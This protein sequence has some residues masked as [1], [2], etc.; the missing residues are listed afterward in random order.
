MDN[1]SLIYRKGK[2]FYCE[3]DHVK[4]TIHAH[5]YPLSTAHLLN[6]SNKKR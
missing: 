5:S 4:I 6:H 1:D 3:S 2:N